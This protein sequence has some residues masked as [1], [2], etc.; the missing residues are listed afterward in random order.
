MK[1]NSMGFMKSV[2]CRKKD[3]LA[4]KS[5]L[6]GLLGKKKIF[7]NNIEEIRTSSRKKRRVEMVQLEWVFLLQA[8]MGI[9]MIIFLHKMNRIKKQ[10]DNIVKEV[11]NYVEFITEV[12]V[13]METGY[14]EEK[15]RGLGRKVSVKSMSRK[16]KEEAQNRLIQS[17]LGE[18]FP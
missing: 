5:L 14:E 8:A 9:L 10:L 1:E 17:V 7:Y 13:D 4:M 11:K 3:K 15:E 16:E 12:D 18:Y 2:T 6:R